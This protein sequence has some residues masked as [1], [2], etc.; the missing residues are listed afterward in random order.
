MSE[1]DTT[2]P[3][4]RA[5]ESKH[6]KRE[7]SDSSAGVALIVVGLIVLGLLFFAFVGDSGLAPADLAETATGGTVAATE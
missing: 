5:L 6:A 3:Y 7:R 2:N 4:R 1:F